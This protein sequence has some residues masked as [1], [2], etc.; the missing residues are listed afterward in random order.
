[1]G[2]DKHQSNK[3]T[4]YYEKVFTRIPRNDIN[5]VPSLAQSTHRLQQVGSP[6]DLEIKLLLIRN[7]VA[8]E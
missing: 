7:Q 8:E 6:F 5:L 4:K 3:E 1:M 2:E